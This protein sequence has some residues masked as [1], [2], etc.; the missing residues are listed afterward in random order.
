MLKAIGALL[1]LALVAGDPALA[2]PRKKKK[3]RRGSRPA[4]AAPVRAEPPP[5]SVRPVSYTHL[6]LPTK[7][8]V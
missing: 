6:T 1:V 4:A 3:N 8:I 2:A 5:P 7:R